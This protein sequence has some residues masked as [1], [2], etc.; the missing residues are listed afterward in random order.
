MPKNEKEAVQWWQRAAGQGFAPA[1]SSLGRALIT[2]GQ[3]VLPG[4]MQAYVWLT[5]SAG[6]GDQEAEQQ[7]AT[8]GKQLKPD[9]LALAKRLVKDWKP[10][11]SRAVGG[12]KPQ[13]GPPPIGVQIGLANNK[14]DLPAVRRGLRL[15]DPIHRQHVASGEGV[16]LLSKGFPAD[17]D[18]Y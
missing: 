18:N 8:L 6:Q 10:A 2:G 4:K 3:G 15:G 14:R 12:D 5:L 9:Q 11:K 13:V 16:R 7:R 17:P 1:Q